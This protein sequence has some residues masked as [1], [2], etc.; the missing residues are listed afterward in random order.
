[1]KTNL[2]KKY[3]KQLLLTMFLLLNI[4]INFTPKGFTVNVQQL[5]AGEGVWSS[6]S[7]WMDEI[8]SGNNWAP[9]TYTN[10]G[11]GSWS[12]TDDVPDVLNTNETANYDIEIP[13][14]PIN[15]D[16]SDIW[17]ST[18]TSELPDW[19]YWDTNIE[20]WNDI[21]NQSY[22]PLRCL[23]DRT[24][25]YNEHTTQSILYQL[26]F[27]SMCFLLNYGNYPSVIYEPI[28]PTVYE[29][30]IGVSYIQG[31]LY[32]WYGTIYYECA[33]EIITRTKRTSLTV[34]YSARPIDE[35]SYFSIAKRNKST[36]SEVFYG[37]YPVTANNVI[38]VQFIDREGLPAAGE[39]I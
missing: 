4:S 6:G 39:F 16:Y 26:C 17:H 35:T 27:G 36:G 21:C 22:N 28:D 24:S 32:N 31:T 37:I 10:D 38:P 25:V 33:N 30:S 11:G 18:P 3:W 13:D 5:Y 14:T 2:L 7:S 23:E 34:R 19:E 12:Y 1:M 15:L 8:L 29:F 9:G 20:D